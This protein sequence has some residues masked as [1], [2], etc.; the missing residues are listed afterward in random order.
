M[1]RVFVWMY[2]WKIFNF[3][4]NKVHNWQ[5]LA[6]NIFWLSRNESSMPSFY[7][8]AYFLQKI[9]FRKFFFSRKMLNELKNSLNRWG[10][11]EF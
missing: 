2:N 11:M 9:T 6:Q 1:S 7:E 8:K 5:W 4:L 3:H 10:C